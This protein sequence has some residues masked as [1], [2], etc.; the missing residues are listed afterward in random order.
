MYQ[1]YYDGYTE[2][3]LNIAKTTPSPIVLSENTAEVTSIKNPKGIFGNFEADD[4]LL[5]GVFLLLLNE[6]CDDKLML[7]II[8]FLFFSGLK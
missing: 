4:I 7:I 3:N 6:D 1:R 8:G 2:D 5:I